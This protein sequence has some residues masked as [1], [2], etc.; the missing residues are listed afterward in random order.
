MVADFSHRGI[1]EETDQAYFPFLDIP[2]SGATLRQD[3]RQAGECVRGDS[4]HHRE[5]D[6]ALPILSLR[7]IENQIDW[8]LTTE[9][10]M[11]TLL[12]GFG[13]V[14]LLLS[15]IGLYGVMSFVVT[16]RTREIGVR[17]ALGATRGTAV[18]LIVRDALFMI[19]SGTAIALVGGWAAGRV[20]SGTPLRRRAPARADD[21]AGDAP[22]G[23]CGSCRGDGAGLARVV[24]EPDGGAAR[25]V[26]DAPR[27]GAAAACLD[28]E[29]Q[30]HEAQPK[31]DR[32][33]RHRHAD[34]AVIN[35]EQEDAR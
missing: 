11:A 9:R 17:L 8:S 10:M 24:G 3:A 23:R 1:R 14:A 26:S 4:R 5:L 28:R 21:R 16:H 19:G 12:T 25:G 22:D 29:R 32:G 6:S 31:R 27:Q 13:V 20:M 35:Q 30:Q 18:W 34:A 33:Q 2:W 7:T 15:V